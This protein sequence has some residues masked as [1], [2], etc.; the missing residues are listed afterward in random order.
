MAASDVTPLSANEISRL[1]ALLDRREIDDCLARVARGT[2]RFDR[3]L[4]LSGFH[5]GAVIST[6]NDT[7]SVEGTYEGGRAFHDQSTLGTLHCLSTSICEIEGDTAYVETYH[8]YCARNLD[9]TNWAAAGR[10]IDQFERRDGVWAIIFRRIVVEWTGKMTP[11][12]IAMFEG[13]KEEKSRLS[14]SRGKDDV[15]Y[16][17]PLKA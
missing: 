11:N 10:Y 12:V 9:D 7:G 14:P 16:L 3:Q 8:I 1:R 17:R 6:G 13:V 2:D 4:F 15:S 5:P